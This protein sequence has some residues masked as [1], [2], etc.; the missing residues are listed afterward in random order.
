MSFTVWTDGSGTTR[1]PAGIG[2]VAHVN[3]LP[4]GEGSLPLANATNQQAEILAAAYA[5]HELPEG[6]DVV[7]VSDSE[8]L[9]LGWN[10][11]P[12]RKRRRNLAHWARL[13]AAVARHRS[14]MF[15]WTRGHVGTEGNERAD[16][17]AG[18]ARRE[19]VRRAACELA[20]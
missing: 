6:Q 13:T 16:R 10:E 18:E 9:V 2:Y 5:L 20:A 12:R 8:Y 4:F 14:V 3:G 11:Y 19:A 15:E 7:I 1:G 17:L